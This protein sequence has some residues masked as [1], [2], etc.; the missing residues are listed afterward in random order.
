MQTYTKLSR[1]ALLRRLTAFTVALLAVGAV[2]PLAGCGSGDDD[3]DPNNSSSREFPLS[4]LSRADVTVNSMVYKCWIMDTPK[5]RGEGMMFLQ[6]FE[7]PGDAGMI[8]VYPEP[9]HQRYFGKNVKFPLD[10]AYLDANKKVLKMAV[11][12]PF[13]EGVIPS[14]VRAQYV[15]ELHQGEFSRR[16]LKVGDTITIP[17][18]VVAKE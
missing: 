9:K 3:D 2:L 18:F 14:D 15:L 17:S 16:K 12:K 6:T 5:K 8:F 10:L 7:V 1:L 11:I 4:N 13:D